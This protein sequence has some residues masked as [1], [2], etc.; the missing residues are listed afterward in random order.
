MSIF[1]DFQYKTS[2]GLRGG[3]SGANRCYVLAH[4]GGGGKNAFS[5]RITDMELNRGT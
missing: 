3:A 1:K 2:G 4:C 5:P